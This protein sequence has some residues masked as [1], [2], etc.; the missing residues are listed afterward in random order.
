MESGQ[1]AN[2]WLQAEAVV[3]A[4][5]EL[6]PEAEDP[7]QLGRFLDRACHGDAPLRELVEDLLG[8]P[9]EADAHLS[10]TVTDARA[11]L[12]EHGGRFPRTGERSLVETREL[13]GPAPAA[14]GVD[15]A[16]LRPGGLRGLESTEPD[17]A[18]DSAAEPASPAR[19]GPYRLCRRIGEGGSGTVFLAERDDG[20]FEQRVAVK[21]LR[22]GSWSY[23]RRRRFEE[24]RRILAR[25][26][27]P[28]IARL[29]DGGTTPEGL[30]YLAMELVEGEPIDRY[31]DRHRLSIE[32][33]LRL[34]LEVCGGVHAA[35]QNLVVH[36]DLKPSNI[37]ITEEGKPKLL[38]F[39]IAR[40]LDSGRDATRTLVP[41]TPRWASPEQLRGEGVTTASDVYSLGLLLRLLL[42]GRQPFEGLA[43]EGRSGSANP[44]GDSELESFAVILERRWQGEQPSRPSLAAAH[45]GRAATAKRAARRRGL[46]PREL[47]RRLRGDLDT[48]VAKALREEPH[49]RYASVA[50]LADDL[51]RHLCKRPVKARPDTWTYR[52]SRFVRRHRLAVASA[53]AFLLS[54]SAGL[55]TLD[56]QVARTAHERDRADRVSRLLA[57]LFAIADPSVSRG[58]TITA[59]ELLDRGA[60]RLAELPPEPET[61]VLAE[62]L[63]RLYTRLGL[64]GEAVPIFERAIEMRRSAAGRPDLDLADTWNA[65]GIA[66]ARQGAYGDAQVA[67]EEAYDLRRAILGD[68]HPQVAASLNNLALLSHDLGHYPRARKLYY[69]ALELDVRLSGADHPDTAVT[70]GNLALL[71]LDEGR[72]AA[73]IER[74][75]R[76]LGVLGIGADAPESALEPMCMMGLALVET[77][78]VD[79]GLGLCRRA[80]ELRRSR[81]GENHPDLARSLETFGRALVAAAL[82]AQAESPLERSL[83]LRRKLLGAGHEE[84]ASSL[85][86]L[87][88]QRLASGL[89]DA[90][91]ARY[92]QALETAEEALPPEHPLLAGHRF[93]LGALLAETA[94]CPEAA[95][96]LAAVLAVRERAWP[97]GGWPR[98]E[99]EAALAL[100]H[101]DAVTLGRATRALIA[102]LGADHHRSRRLEAWGTLLAVPAE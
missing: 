39:G 48:I 29:I 78:Q 27:H 80:V 53:V 67:F 37:H 94:R 18:A 65:L 25:L 42:C 35:H 3:L 15:G 63:A 32:A 47:E 84:M 88:D 21:V 30:P 81:W 19:A 60:E 57:D 9:G 26:E 45:G 97:A 31:C 58:N 62:T 85:A 77:G 93:R 10:A 82:P 50:Q 83:V 44:E 14:S 79:R 22:G 73:A 49:R 40:W 34:F 55:I 43:P 61:A 68:D 96:L 102:A 59:R 90:A 99:A 8:D 91:E 75:G 23:E 11:G 41:M 101:G 54:I 95:P 16:E 89:A 20:L 38:D 86:A 69:R 64:A 17:P 52:L 92:R 6:G 87:G 1:I 13:A 4:A 100:C 36:R 28:A 98:H 76:V 46:R 74:Y 71:E 5:G 56:Q 2:R 33:R 70:R 72:Y 66:R 7:E 12:A 51:E 24:E